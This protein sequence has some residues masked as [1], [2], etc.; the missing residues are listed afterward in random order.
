MGGAASCDAAQTPTSNS[1]NILRNFQDGARKR[2]EPQQFEK[3]SYLHCDCGIWH[4]FGRPDRPSNPDNIA[5]RSG[6]LQ[7]RHATRTIFRHRLDLVI[8]GVLARTTG[9]LL[10]NAVVALYLA[11][12]GAIA[13]I[14]GPLLWPA[15]ALHAVVALLLIWARR[16]R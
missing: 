7:R 16:D 4:R 11:Y 12:L 6:D 15:V 10:Y 9:I 3:T 5:A 8:I 14:G 2:N 1:T 13:H